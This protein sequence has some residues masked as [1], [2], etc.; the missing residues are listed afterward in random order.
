MEQSPSKSF[1]RSCSKSKAKLCNSSPIN[2]IHHRQKE[3][4][5]SKQTQKWLISSDCLKST[6]AS[7]KKKAAIQ[8]QAKPD[9]SLTN[10]WKRRQCVRETTLDKLRSKNFRT[11]KRHKNHNSWSFHKLGTTT[12]QIM[13]QLLI[14]RWKNWKRSIW[15]SSSSSKRKSGKN[16]EPS[17]SF[18]RIF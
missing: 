16:S 6:A 2:T 9:K 13:K 15:L 11:L 5:T 3:W 10:F 18:R 7:V 12:C 1:C 14:S 17:K 4:S 8:K